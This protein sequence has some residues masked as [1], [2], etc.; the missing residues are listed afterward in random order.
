M[1]DHDVGDRSQLIDQALG[2]VGRN[3]ELLDAFVSADYTIADMPVNLRLGKQVINWGES[4]FI[5]NGNNVFNPIDVARLPPSRFGNQGS[6]ASGQRGLGLDF[7]AV[8]RLARRLLRARLGA[9]RTRSVRHAVLG[10]RRR[11]ARQRSRRQRRPR[12]VPVRQPVHRARAAIAIGGERHAATVCSARLQ[13][14]LRSGPLADSDVAGNGRPDRT[15]RTTPFVDYDT[16]VYDR[17][18]RSGHELGLIGTLELGRLHASHAGI[19]IAR[20]RHLRRATTANSVCRRRYYAEELGGTEFGFYFQNY[21]S[22]LPF[23][24]AKRA[25]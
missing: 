15:A 4:T 18:A 16:R 5:L 14:R 19:V 6:A 8:R 7:A 17:P 24:I 2:D 21:H 11:R 23:A 1:N 25:R 3:Y 20:Q 12:S 10:R 22:R 13:L 9:V